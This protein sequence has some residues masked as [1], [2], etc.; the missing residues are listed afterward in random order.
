MA[1]FNTILLSA[2]PLALAIF[3]K[4]LEEDVIFQ[5]SLHPPFFL[6]PLNSTLFPSFESKI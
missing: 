6:F 5:V 1:G 3:E 4:D 2:P